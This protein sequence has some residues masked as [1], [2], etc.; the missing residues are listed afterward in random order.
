MKRI[1]TNITLKS[2][3][4]LVHACKWM[5]GLHNVCTRWRLWTSRPGR[6]IPGKNTGTH[7]IGGGVDP[8]DGLDVLENT[9][10]NLLS[11]TGLEPLIVHEHYGLKKKRDDGT[12]IIPNALAVEMNESELKYL[13]SDCHLVSSFKH[14]YIIKYWNICGAFQR[15]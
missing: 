6:F 4:I 9:N 10:K 8:R 2:K 13:F 11:V 12:F 7:R 15:K 3:V 5:K 1:R 14:F